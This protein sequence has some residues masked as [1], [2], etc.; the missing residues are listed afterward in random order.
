MRVEKYMSLVPITIR[1][2]TA[3]WEAF[4]IMQEKDLHHIPVV[5]ESNAVVGLI[6][7]RDLQIAAMHFKEASVDVS[8]VMHSP[9]VTISPGERLSEAAKQMI[10]N[11]I[12]GLPVLDSNGQ[13]VGILTE[14]D[15]LRALIDQLGKE[16][17]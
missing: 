5:N 9:V 10:D 11:R 14:T 17:L 1:D 16:D 7:R 4:D 8:E 13:I 6:T 3:Y 15:L 12:G 2:D